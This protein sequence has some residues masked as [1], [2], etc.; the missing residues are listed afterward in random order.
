MLMV[1]LISVPASAGSREG[2]IG[3]QSGYTPATVSYSSTA[4]T[5]YHWF[6]LAGS[7]T[8][9]NTTR[10]WSGWYGRTNGS[11][12]VSASTLTSGYAYCY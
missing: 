11:W 1:L 3:C 5:H 12:Y 4:T 9:Y 10:A 8:K 7:S 2:Q 6:E